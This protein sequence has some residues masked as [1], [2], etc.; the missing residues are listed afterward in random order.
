QVSGAG[1]TDGELAPVRRRSS[2]LA[3]LDDNLVAAISIEVETEDCKGPV[4]YVKVLIEGPL[5]TV[6]D[7]K[8]EVVLPKSVQHRKIVRALLD[9]KIGLSIA[10]QPAPSQLTRSREHLLGDQ[11]RVPLIKVALVSQS[12]RLEGSRKFLRRTR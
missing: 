9:N 10:R 7:A 8:P 11:N 12:K 2:A 1:L 3:V 6:A 4:G 5:I